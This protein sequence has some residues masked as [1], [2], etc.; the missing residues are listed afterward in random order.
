MQ[1][2]R[3]LTWL[4]NAFSSQQFNRIYVVWIKSIYTR[5]KRNAW[6]TTRI[7]IN[8][9]KKKNGRDI[10]Y[11]M[12][13]NQNTVYSRYS[14]I[15]HILIP[16]CAYQTHS[17]T[18]KFMKLPPIKPMTKLKL[19]WKLR[20][21]DYKY[22]KINDK[23]TRHRTPFHDMVFRIHIS[24]TYMC[25]CWWRCG[26]HMHC[27]RARLMYYPKNC[28][29]LFIDVWHFGALN[30]NT[31][32]IVCEARILR[33]AWATLLFD[34]AAVFWSMW[35]LLIGDS[36][37]RQCRRYCR[38]H[39]PYRANDCVAIDVDGK[40]HHYCPASGPFRHTQSDNFI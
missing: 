30:L 29:N 40:M 37:W 2:G 13:F 5:T 20:V 32:Y 39:T 33:L 7:V 21:R 24:L 23:M 16:L 35:T 31:T 19:I 22:G 27:I 18:T 9:E 28:V 8:L 38:C 11:T 10:Q 1:F 14:H 34:A 36:C 3:Q 6:P 26:A 12:P 4:C 17:I 25:E 15:S